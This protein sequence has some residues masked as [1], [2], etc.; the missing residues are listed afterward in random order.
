MQQ[1]I[2]KIQAIFIISPIVPGCIISL[3]K[4]LALSM[5]FIDYGYSLLPSYGLRL[6]KDHKKKH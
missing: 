5:S 6:Q 1:D 3:L 2:L 4:W